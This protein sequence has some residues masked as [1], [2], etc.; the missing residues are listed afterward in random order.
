MTVQLKEEKH[1]PALDGL[2]G[3]AILIVL[4]FHTCLAPIDSVSNPLARGLIHL[5][6]VGWTGVDLFFVLSGFLI[7]RILFDARSATNYFTVFYARRSLRIFPIYYLSVIAIFWIWP[8]LSS[9]SSF[10]RLHNAGHFGHL[11]QLWY[12]FN[13]VNIRTAFYP[14]LIPIVTHYWTLSIEEQFY[15]IWPA[16][17]YYLRERWIV[18]VC[19][20]GIVIALVL[21]N[22]HVV[23]VI[24][25]TH[26]NF[27][28]RLTPFRVDS[29]LFGALLVSLLRW[30]R[31][32]SDRR[33][34]WIAA[35]V[36]L[37]TLT[38][39]V[40]YASDDPA[41]G[42]YT[43]TA[44]GILY[45]ALL[46]LCLKSSAVSRIFRLRILRTMG[47]YSYS[48]YLL[49]PIVIS[50][51][52]VPFGHILHGRQL[53]PGNIYGSQLL[54]ATMQIVACFAVAR[55][56]WAL[57]ESPMLSYKQ[58][59]RYNMETAS[60]IPASVPAPALAH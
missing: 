51:V 52:V 40:A 55:I 57:I 6:S 5:A 9:H 17:V 15:V 39:L 26:S 37:V 45:S 22:L 58:Y 49:H 36:F 27:T 44:L 46:I 12:W 34:V 1:I 47:K 48:V 13:L 54:M 33:I 41:K 21:R 59:F 18:A 35:V 11:E 43:F 25:A 38:L 3:I 14:L 50:W 60:S 19:I 56:T 42:R 20:S 4:M 32:P 28:Y 23:Q 10:F 24:N 31:R 2:R 30:S 16:I 53:I 7:T 29:L 8:Y